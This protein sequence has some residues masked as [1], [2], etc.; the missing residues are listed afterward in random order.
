MPNRKKVM[1]TKDAPLSSHLAVC[2]LLRISSD[3][4]SNLVEITTGET[5]HIQQIYIDEPSM[6]HCPRI[7]IFKT[8]FPKCM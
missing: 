4:A 1:L 2:I 6:Q 3:K 5:R 8:G 7:C